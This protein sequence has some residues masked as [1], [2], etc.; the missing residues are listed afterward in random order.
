L[1]NDFEITA[2][3]SDGVLKVVLE[4]SVNFEVDVSMAVLC[5]A[6][7]DLVKIVANLETLAMLLYD[8]LDEFVSRLG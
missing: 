6:V 4:V 3:L 1:L 7:G 5:F 8:S 2:K